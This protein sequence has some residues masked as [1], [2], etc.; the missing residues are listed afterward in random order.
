MPR[1]AKGLKMIGLYRPTGYWQTQTAKEDWAA[2]EGFAI[3]NGLGEIVEELTPP[4]NW[5]WRRIDISIRKLR[6]A[7]GEIGA[8]FVLPSAK[9]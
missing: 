3:K 8:E 2:I 1:R 4:V 5:G 9:G 6:E 7:L